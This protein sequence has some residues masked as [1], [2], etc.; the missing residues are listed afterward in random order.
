MQK[1]W[2]LPIVG[3]LILGGFGFWWQSQTPQD[4]QTANGLQV[5]D[6]TELDSEAVGLENTT[7]RDLQPGPS[8]PDERKVVQETSPRLPSKVK[9]SK[10]LSPGGDALWI[11][12]RVVFHEDTP[13]GEKLQIVARGRAFAKDSEGRREHV[14]QLEADGTFRVAVSPETKVARLVVLGDYLYL[15]QPYIWKAE[16]A[17]AGGEIVLVPALGTMI[18]IQ[19]KVP[20]G[21]DAE[22]RNFKASYNGF[23][24]YAGETTPELLPG[25]IVRL[26]GLP[27]AESS[28]WGGHFEC[29]ADGFSEISF[30]PDPGAA[31][32]V[33]VLELDLQ[34]A[35]VL[36][37]MVTDETGQP[38]LDGRVVADIQNDIASSYIGPRVDGVALE[39][40]RYEITGLEPGDYKMLFQGSGFIF[41]PVM[42]RGLL[43]GQ[44]LQQDLVLSRGKSIRGSVT[45]PRGEPAF[46]A[47]VRLLGYEASRNESGCYPDRMAKV[48]EEGHFAMHGFGDEGPFGVLVTGVPPGIEPPK[49]KSKLKLRRWLRDNEVQVQAGDIAPGG[50]P[51]ALVIGESGHDLAGRVLDDRGEPIQRFKVTIAPRVGEEASLSSAG[52]QRKSFESE[53]GRFVLPNLSPGEWGVVASA[54]GHLEAEVQWIE[55][56]AKAELDLRINRASTIRGKVLAGGPNR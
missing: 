50:P 52:R 13:P 9:S 7:M 56:P 28:R 2:L 39:K 43:G 11:E 16:E 19:L 32:A 5:G 31:G 41:E 51:L 24:D 40:G 47:E 14:V 49:S 42:V 33:E 22:L 29:T 48:D 34:P 26:R 27:S 21:G 8:G 6:R 3:L 25:N 30:S 45:W 54:F 15:P 55:I 1:K 36:F 44:R 46:G 53:E 17:Q 12:G 4:K 38:V 23:N 37:G 10:P 18:E 20:V 35:G